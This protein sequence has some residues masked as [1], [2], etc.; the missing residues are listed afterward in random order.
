MT[1]WPE[2]EKLLILTHTDADKLSW[3]KGHWKLP[4]SETDFGQLGI[5]RE[6][7]AADL[8]S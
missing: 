8:L 1:H 4:A 3:L 5:S 2:A 6:P 7:L